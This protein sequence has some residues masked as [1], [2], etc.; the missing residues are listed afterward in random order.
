M[1]HH[2]INEL[3]Q[4]KRVVDR[5]SAEGSTCNGCSLTHVDAV[6]VEGVEVERVGGVCLHEGEEDQEDQIPH[7]RQLAIPSRCPR[8]T[9]R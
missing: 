3:L 6:S 7:R 1:G 9:S 4:A 2:R 5:L 8:L